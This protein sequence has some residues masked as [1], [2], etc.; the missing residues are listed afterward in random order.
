MLLSQSNPPGNRRYWRRRI[1]STRF[2]IWVL[3]ILLIAEPAL[4]S[5]TVERVVTHNRWSIQASLSETFFG[6]M[7]DAYIPITN[8]SLTSDQALRILASTDLHNAGTTMYNLFR[9]DTQHFNQLSR[10][11]STLLSLQNLSYVLSLT[12]P[13][14]LVL[15]NLLISIGTRIV[16]AYHLNGTNVYSVPFWYW[17]PSPPNE[18]LLNQAVDLTKLP[19]LPCFDYQSCNNVPLRW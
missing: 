3:L 10:I 6:Q 19:G 2:L 18:D 17:G 11:S 7:N 4:V 1:R 14:R 12:S 8:Q 16:D 9:V 13:Q 5:W 15:A